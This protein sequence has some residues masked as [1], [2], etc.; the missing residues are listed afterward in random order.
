MWKGLILACL[1]GT[2]ISDCTPD[3]HRVVVESFRPP[4]KNYSSLGT[5]QFESMAFAADVVPHG[6]VVKIYCSSVTKQGGPGA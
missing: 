1:A 6:S 5:C 2:P 4:T 3:N